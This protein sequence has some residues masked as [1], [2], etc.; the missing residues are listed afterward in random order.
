MKQA[1]QTGILILVGILIIAGLV[2][3]VYYLGTRKPITVVPSPSPTPSNTSPIPND[4]GETDNWKTY[5]N[6]YY[7]IIFKYPPEW[8]IGTQIGTDNSSFFITLSAPVQRS[9]LGDNINI[10][11]HDNKANLSMEQYI[12]KIAGNGPYHYKEVEINGIQAREYSDLPEAS[13]VRRLYIKHGSYI[14]EI[15]IQSDSEDHLEPFEKLLSTFKFT[16]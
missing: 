3:G 2:G 11:I 7:S 13:Y 16:K 15:S 12:F 10:D 8:K 1:G 6:N 5:T 4:T 9:Q 14:H